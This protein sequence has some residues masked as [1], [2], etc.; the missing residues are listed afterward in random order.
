MAV[1]ERAAAFPKLCPAFQ[2]D[3]LCL[4]EFRDFQLCLCV[5]FQKA[6]ELRVAETMV[7]MKGDREVV[8][9][10]HASGFIVL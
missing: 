9:R 4:L 6:L 3:R 1:V 2:F 8:P 7:D 5:V 10:V